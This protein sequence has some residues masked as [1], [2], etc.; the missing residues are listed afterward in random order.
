[1]VQ[2]IEPTEMCHGLKSQE[3]RKI[4]GLENRDSTILENSLNC[5]DTFK[6][7]GVADWT[8]WRGVINL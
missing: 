3:V 5:G 7:L 1:L 8:H 2:N 6:S 4:E